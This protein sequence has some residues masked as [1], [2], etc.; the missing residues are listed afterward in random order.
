MKRREFI[1]LVGGAAAWPITAHAQQATTMPV[2]GFLHV[3]SSTPMAHVL[4][5]LDRGLKETGYQRDRICE[6]NIAGQTANTTVCQRWRPIL[7][8]L[9]WR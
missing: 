5:G 1:S 9:K 3:A 7:S 4:V 2:I 8:T 6:L